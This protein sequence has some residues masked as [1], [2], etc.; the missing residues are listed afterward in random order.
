MVSLKRFELSA[1]P[2]RPEASRRIAIERLERLELT[3]P[4]VNGAKRWNGWNH[5]DRLRLRESGGFQLE[6]A[7]PKLL[8][9]AHSALPKSMPCAG[10]PGG[11]CQDIQASF[12]TAAHTQQDL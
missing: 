9:R 10:R 6:K 3:G 8:N 12:F 7:A 1:C 5:W 2:E 4:M 11:G